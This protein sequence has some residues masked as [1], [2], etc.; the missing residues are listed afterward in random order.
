[1]KPAIVPTGSSGGL[2]PEPAI[3]PAGSSAPDPASDRSNSGSEPAIPPAG[4]EL[5]RRSRCEPLRTVIVAA[6]EAGLSAQRI[7]QDLVTDHQFCGSYDSVK[8][9][10]RRLGA[11]E[12]LPFRRIE[13]EPGHEAQVDFGQGA[14]VLEE[15]APTAPRAASGL[16]LLAQRLHRGFLS[17]DHGE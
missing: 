7:Y 6:W 17:T 8:R 5:G 14:W 1:S 12:P 15:G 4:S 11:A 10:V 3:S 2:G 13:C 9:F 16:E